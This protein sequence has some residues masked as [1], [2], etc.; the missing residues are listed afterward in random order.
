[1]VEYSSDATAPPLWCDKLRLEFVQ[2]EMRL[3]S[4]SA[5][6]G[7][8]YSSINWIYHSYNQAKALM[9]AGP[10]S[11]VRHPEWTSKLLHSLGNPDQS[12][13]NVAVTGSKGKGSHAILTAA[14][15][16]QMGLHV[17]L[18]TGPHLVDFMER[19]RVDGEVMLETEFISYVENLKQHVSDW[20]LPAGQYFGPVGLLAVIAV[21]WFR[22]RQTDV[23]IFELGRGALHDDVN[24]VHHEGAI[25]APIFLE[26][27]RELGST[28]A[29]VGYEKSGIVT[30][31][32]R[33]A[34]S[35]PQSGVVEDTL[36]NA[37]QQAT[38]SSQGIFTLGLDFH[39][40]SVTS[41]EFGDVATISTRFNSTEVRLPQRSKDIPLAPYLVD[42]TAV[43]LAAAQ[44]IVR[45]IRPDWTAP[46]QIDLHSLNLP[47]RLQIIATAPTVIVDG[48]IHGRSAELVRVFLRAWR[49][50]GHEG[51]V[52]ACIG[53]PADKD[54]RGV[55][56]TLAADLDWVVV[57]SAHNPHLKF[58]ET[59]AQ[60]S[61][62]W[63]ADVTEEPYLEEALATA[64]ER[65]GGR[66][67]LL[68]ILGTQ[69]LVGDA[70]R[71]F[72][73]DTR[74]IWRR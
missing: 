42:N 58:D 69:S 36:H 74:S 20:Q 40:E 61:S 52:G 13:Y 43:A 41:N 59:L 8:G 54:G 66:D 31:N 55:V 38:T 6:R 24:R 48:T 9:S 46:P 27:Q 11:V 49:A 25:I 26:H 73:V 29:E 70:M 34:F 4:T 17:G 67:D 47:G 35:H 32:T 1:M 7:I 28:L 71:M 60:A 62:Q 10:D 68:L 44:Q 22:A 56:Q 23:N 37:F 39:V 50:A 45:D 21:Q 72:A 16:Q 64:M 15:L 5:S 51:R 18:F 65:L 3:L 19:F 2:G 53:I 57:C 63:L 30:A 12:M 33:W 14:I